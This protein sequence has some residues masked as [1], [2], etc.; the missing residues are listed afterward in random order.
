M[1]APA[2]SITFGNASSDAAPNAISVSVNIADGKSKSGTQAC[3]YLTDHLIAIKLNIL[4]AHSMSNLVDFLKAD[5]TVDSNA[6]LLRDS[7]PLDPEA[8]VAELKLE[9]GAILTLDPPSH[10]RSTSPAAESKAVATSESSSTSTPASTATSTPRTSTPAKKSRKPRCSKEACNA[11]A[12]PIVGDC[13]F[14]QKRFCGK[15]RMLESHN[16]DGLEDARRADKDRNTAKLEGERTVML[17]G[18]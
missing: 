10:R 14:C 9:S 18:L 1:S 12:Q 6:R 7:Q 5:T 15:H 16:C 11:P 17:R 8:T 3:A 2:N 13:G 4:P